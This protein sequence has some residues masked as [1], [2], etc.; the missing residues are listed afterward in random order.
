MRRAL[1]C[2]L[3]AE[4]IERVVVAARLARGHRRGAAVRG[5]ADLRLDFLGQSLAVD[6]FRAH[7]A[8]LRWDRHYCR[9]IAA[10]V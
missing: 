5:D 1:R 6:D 2:R 3:P 7:E 9:T 8:F 10:S 4:A